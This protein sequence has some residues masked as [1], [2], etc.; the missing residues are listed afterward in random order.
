MRLPRLPGPAAMS[1]EIVKLQSL[2]GTLSTHLRI[3]VVRVSRLHKAALIQIEDG[4]TQ[5]VR[6][7]GKI[8]LAVE[9]DVH[10]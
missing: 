2:T 10:E 7:G 3:R 6:D 1:A 8:D 5:W 4:P 9:Y